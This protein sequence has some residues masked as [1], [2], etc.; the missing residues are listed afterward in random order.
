MK[1]LYFFILTL[2]L[3]F[4]ATSEAKDI[5]KVPPQKVVHVLHEV[6]HS[7]WAPSYVII[8]KD[9]SAWKTDYWESDVP[10]EGDVIKSS[11]GSLFVNTKGDEHYTLENIGTIIYT[12]LKIQ[13]ILSSSPINPE[14]DF[15]QEFLLV[16]YEKISTE[17]IKL[18][19]LSNQLIYHDEAYVDENFEGWDSA[20]SLRL[21]RPDETQEQEY[22]VYLERKEIRKVESL[23][24]DTTKL[25][26]INPESQSFTLEE[27]DRPWH[28]LQSFADLMTTWEPSDKICVHQLMELNEAREEE[29][30]DVVDT[31]EEL[32]F[33]ALLLRLQLGINLTKE[34]IDTWNLRIG[35]AM[36]LNTEQVVLIWDW[37]PPVSTN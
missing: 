8:L 15:D 35:L 21:I 23:V 30:Y 11:D 28:T 13:K 37:I 34:I 32:H 29:D 24:Y 14:K 2:V 17:A 3:S 20:D 26:D 19:V 6:G 1:Y 10:S 12:P 25:L 5:T 27:S 4:T 7:Y 22:L 9:G 31:E 18:L 33:P 36:N 16:G